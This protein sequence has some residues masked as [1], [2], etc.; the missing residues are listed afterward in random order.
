MSVRLSLAAGAIVGA[1]ASLLLSQ[2]YMHLVALPV[3]REQARA[4]ERAEMDAA[5]NKAI[6]ELTNE[7]DR[8]RVNRR[9]CR[10]RGGVYLVGSGKCLERAAQSGG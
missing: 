2:A 1:L 6:G 4:L 8:A 5:T 9:L 3:A 7:A 10:E